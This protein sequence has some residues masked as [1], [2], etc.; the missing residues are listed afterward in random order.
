MKKIL[1]SLA[2]SCL[3][4]PLFA[5]LIE[6]NP[7]TATCIDPSGKIT[8]RQP[9]QNN[10]SPNQNLPCG[11]GTSEDNPAWWIIRPAG[12]TL[13]FSVTTANCVAGGCGLGVQMTLWEGD[14]CGSVTAIDC[15]V[16]T[17][18]TFTS[19]VTPCKIYYLQIDGLCECQCNVTLTYDKNQILRT[20]P[21]PIITGPKSACVGATLKLCAEIPGLPGCIPDGYSWRVDPV[22]SATITPIPGEL[23]C[24]NIKIINRPSTGKIKVCA[25]PKFNGK[26]PPTVQEECFE[27]DIATIANA[28]CNVSIC[29]EEQPFEFDLGNCVKASNPTITN[30]ITPNKLII[31][32]P[33]GTKKL[34]QISY[35][36]DGANCSGV[37]S[38]NIEVLE[39][40]TRQLAPILLCE[41][42]TTNVAGQLLTCQ[43]AGVNIKKIIKV[44]NPKPSRCDT[45]FETLVQCLK[46]KPKIV[47]IGALD[48]ST[49][50]LTLNA[51]GIETTTLPLD[52]SNTIY[53]GKGKREF[54]WYKDGILM[55]NETNPT[56]DVTTTGKYKVELKF[57]YEISMM[58][59]GKAGKWSKTCTESA[60]VEI[61]GSS[62]TAVAETPIAMSQ[63]CA[64]A[65]SKFYI[66]PDK[67][68]QQYT[69]T[70]IGAT[71]LSQSNNPNTKVEAEVKNIGQPF[72]VCLTKKACNINSAP[73][74]VTIT[75][76]SQANK[77]QI[78]GDSI[79]C[80]N[81][82]SI[83]K[84]KNPSQSPFAKYAWTVSDGVI[85]Y[86]N[87]DS[88]EISVQWNT[89]QPTANVKVSLK[90]EC[91]NSES[92]LKI[93]FIP[94]LGNANNIQG[95]LEVCQNEIVT[96][97]VDSVV[98][99]TKYQWK[100]AK[101]GEI[102]GS[103]FGQNITV[104]WTTEGNQELCVKA[105][106][107]CSPDGT[108]FFC[109][110][111]AV[112][113]TP[114][115]YA[116]VDQK[117][118]G[119]S[120]YLIG[121]KSSTGTT[122]WLNITNLG[123]IEIENKS[124]T[125]TKIKTDTC[126][127]WKFQLKETNNGCVGVDTMTVQFS[128]APK[129]SSFDYFCD[130]TNNTYRI[131]VG[132]KDC[133]APYSTVDSK[134]PI[135]FTNKSLTI[136]NILQQDSVWSFKI[137]NAQFCVTE[138]PIRVNCQC[139]SKPVFAGNDF[140]VCGLETELNAAP[141][142]SNAIGKWKGNFSFISDENAN[143]PIVVVDKPGT[144]QFWWI[145]KNG[146][147]I[148]SSSVNVTF[149][150]IPNI[151]A[152]SNS[153]LC[154]GDTLKFFAEGAAIYQWSSSNG[155]SSSLQNPTLIASNS[156][157]YTME[158]TNNEGCKNSINLNVV[159][160]LKPQIT[161]ISNSPVC[162]GKIAL[163]FA[164]GDGKEYLWTGPDNFSSTSKSPSINDVQSKNAGLYVVTVTNSLNCKAV[165][166][167]NLIVENCI[168]SK[169]VVTK[170]IY[171]YPNPVNNLL[172]IETEDVIAEI[173]IFNNL[174][175]VVVKQSFNQSKVVLDLS[176]LTTAHYTLKVKWQT[177]EERELKIIKR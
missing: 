136:D 119:D 56:L 130:K 53:Q 127:L 157:I 76:I 18:G 16:G 124:S 77:P 1:F 138:I 98:A 166:S 102:I 144:Y 158:G 5:Q 173:S 175:Q 70:A 147:C 80:K 125:F 45:T 57:T 121:Q 85:S 24:A 154:E 68:A 95:K 141:T 30:T 17:S 93:K 94:T 177:G 9:N 91:S 83:L 36:V 105:I 25:K 140:S 143:K 4:L 169:D 170:P 118:C 163:F 6:G 31:N 27:I 71:I 152:S 106:N 32:Y 176:N 11:S 115:P 74:C 145:V 55:P 134:Y 117:L 149:K 126:G 120:T 89:I 7:C 19:S 123:K 79:V 103:E 8:G 160:I 155:F 129:V 122:E 168:S 150:A 96:Y 60:E 33:A 162:E 67:N 172:N 62:G 104:R 14:A 114:K 161:V 34:E 148:D 46:V 139:I 50:K 78:E 92:G 43:D 47:G 40:S 69:W 73:S 41:N 51:G 29:P 167:S 146:A 171:I 108:S 159:V 59:D 100:L 156:A 164:A 82:T 12:N 42:E 132:L 20:V 64:N 26:C 87:I 49:T 63:S 48:C 99:A 10:V 3:F 137:Q 58:L 113:F 28:T 112:K 142:P 88:T 37:A 165:V 109:K 84:I 66:N 81:K 65:T 13:T 2:F 107:D 54:Q 15:V 52:I 128:F 153:P 135:N 75:P 72:S 97:R 151:K 39:K 110:T 22:T 21:K 38:L 101:G 111:I 90:D 44:G 131:I 86:T 133:D 23:F 116:G 61:N 174:G 35:A